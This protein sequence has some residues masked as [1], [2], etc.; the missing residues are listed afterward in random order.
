MRIPPYY[1][2]PSWQR[3]FSGMAVGAA[4]SWCIFLYIH[5]VWMEEKSALIAK[6]K[7][8][9]TDL[10]NDIKI[11]QDDYKA[12]NEKNLEQLTIQEIK[13]KIT[14]GKKYELDLLGVYEAEEK[15]KDDLSLFLAKDLEYV[16]KSRELIKKMIENKVIPLNGKRY[17][18]RITSMVVYTTVNIQL[19]VYLDE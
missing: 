18:V 16:Y 12:L 3:F 15:I 4:L 11:W 9:I 8:D 5:G 17:R 1:R 2:S 7:Q 13:I 19:E 14:N 10:T 6:Q